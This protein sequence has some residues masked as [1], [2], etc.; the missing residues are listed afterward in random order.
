V[1]ASL[2]KTFSAE[3][4][5]AH[6]QRVANDTELRRSRQAQR[7]NLTA[8]LPKLQAKAA[9][10]AKMVADLDDAGA[11]LGEYQQVQQQVKDAKATLEYLDK[12]DHQDVMA[13]A[14]AAQLEATWSDWIAQADKDAGVARQTLRKVLASP[15][16]VRP[17]GKGTWTFAGFSKYS[18][19][20]KG[21][22]GKDRLV[23]TVLSELRDSET[24]AKM[25]ARLNQALAGTLAGLVPEGTKVR[26]VLQEEDEPETPRPIAGGSDA[27]DDVPQGCRG[28]EVGS[29]D[30]VPKP[31]T[32]RGTPAEPWRPSM[33]RECH[34]ATSGRRSAHGRA[35]SN[36]AAAWS[37]VT[38]A[39]RRPTIC[40]P[41][42]SPAGVNP[43]GTVTA[44][45]PVKLNG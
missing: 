22:I 3:S 17:T 41:T 44:G 21:G 11:L 25:M 9:R 2:R 28:Y 40:R 14:D 24:A 39:R 20:I 10:L 6:Q 33:T 8:E 27:G 32:A 1:I 42:G 13:A 23:S 35:R 12:A 19:I 38:S 4:F 29:S 37:T 36:A 26:F 31:P 43:A 7:D 18:E 5:L 45:W 16:A 34:E 15:I 30:M